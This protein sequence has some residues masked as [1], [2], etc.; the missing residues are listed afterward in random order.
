MAGGTPDRTVIIACSTI[1]P[2]L[3]EAQARCGCVYPVFYMDA[4]LHDRPDDLRAAVQENLD[5][6]EEVEQKYEINKHD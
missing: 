1:R 3:E 2:E 6:L 4:M 5:R